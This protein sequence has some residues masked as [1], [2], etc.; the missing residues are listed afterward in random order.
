MLKKRSNVLEVH[1]FRQTS[2]EAIV[3]ATIRG[4]G[5]LLH[6]VDLADLLEEFLD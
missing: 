3:E 1:P 6:G 4:K 5:N 2:A